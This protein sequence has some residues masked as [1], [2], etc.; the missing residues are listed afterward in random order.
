MNL[1]NI[2]RIALN[3]IILS[4]LLNSF[5]CAQS[6]SVSLEDFST[7][8]VHLD[9]H[10]SQH[11]EGIG[12]QFNKEEWQKTLK[13]AN[14]NSI[15]IFAKGHHGYSYY[16]TKVGT[17]HP[18]LEFDL[19]KAQIEA[20]HEI[21]VKCPFYF[22]IGWSVLDEE[23]FPDAV[24]KN[25]KGQ[26]TSHKRTAK[27]KDSD[28]YP[29]TTWNLMMPEGDY[30]KMIVAQTEE[31][32]KNYEVD[33]FWYDIIPI[34]Q[35]NFDEKS[36]AAMKAAGVDIKDKAAIEK[37]HV[38]K[39]ELFLKS[40]NDVIKKYH[41]EA[42][43]FYNW[44]TNLRHPNAFK[45]RLYDYNTSFDLEDLPTA[46]HGYDVFAMRAKYFCNENKPVTGMSGKFHTA[47]GE[48]GGF[49]YPNALKYEAAAMI[50]FGSNVN[51]GDQLHPNGKF[52]KETYNNLK[53]GFDYVEKIEEYGPGG[54]HEARVGLW[55]A[56]D[57]KH[58]QAASLL[59]LSTQTNFNV[60]NN[61]DDWSGFEVIVVPSIPCISNED[62]KRFD[63]YLKNGGK[64]V[65]IGDGA[66]N[67]AKNDFVFDL[68]AK[69]LG[70][71]NYD[72]DYTV[73]GDKLANNVVSTP[74]LNYK[75]A[76]RT[77]LEKGTEILANIREPYF[78]RTKA[79][80]TSHKNTPNRTENAAHPA[81]F[82]KG[83]IVVIA[84]ELDMMYKEY[85]AQIH[86]ELFKN[87]LDQLLVSPMVSVDLPSSGRINLLHFPEKNRYV[88]HLLY[89]SPIQRGITQVIDDLIPIYD[90]KVVV[91][92]DEEIKDA[93][94]VPGNQK[95]KMKKSDGKVSLIVPK[96]E[97][98][99]AL[100]LEY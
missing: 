69:Y 74:F 1:K 24:I 52:D 18:N 87:V 58:E 75:P 39:I 55:M 95:L 4:T 11:L 63:K 76:Y 34:S 7:R 79:H 92:F 23:K 27:L 38:E 99:T 56:F 90:T 13:S 73:V 100:I 9:F 8:Q 42:S 2:V 66:L 35:I 50:A 44:T 45:Y 94:L 82:R 15:N 53:I 26:V 3:T 91:D 65:L 43:I 51:F 60:I 59:L 88:V 97:C 67:E 41:P 80:Y 85:G 36:I 10:T 86:R 21:G 5:I 68:G 46:W 47:W 20:S 32:C 48:F 49:K 19:L 78:S 16:P 54:K 33:G 83:N 71:A 84:H 77:A 40:C 22:A 29:Q 14:V 62:E 89:G 37:Y 96:F 93:Y 70:K 61:L 31:L 6:P 81:I 25:R 12:S 30:L 17:Q 28:P 98:H 72:V 64:L 57:N